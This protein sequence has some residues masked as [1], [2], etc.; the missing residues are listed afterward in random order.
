M[1]NKNKFEWGEIKPETTT[2]PYTLK[3]GVKSNNDEIIL[4]FD[5]DDVQY[6]EINFPDKTG[7]I[8]KKNDQ[9]GYASIDGT[10]IIEPQYEGLKI[11]DQSFATFSRNNQFGILGADGRQLVEPWFDFFKINTDSTIMAG[12]G[13]IDIPILKEDIL[14]GTVQNQITDAKNQADSFDD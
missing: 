3:W 10:I 2:N 12:R 8:I 9:F 7:F 1:F 14:N 5:Y 13:G 4:P 11:I 6:S